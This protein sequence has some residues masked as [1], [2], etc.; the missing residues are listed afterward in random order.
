MIEDVWFWHFIGLNWSMRNC[1]RKLQQTSFLLVECCEL[2]EGFD[3]HVAGGVWCL[4]HSWFTYSYIR[5]HEVMS[6]ALRNCRWSNNKLPSH[7]AWKLHTN[8]HSF[9]SSFFLFVW[10]LN[11]CVAS[12]RLNFWMFAWK[13]FDQSCLEHKFGNEKVAGSTFGCRSLLRSSLHENLHGKCSKKLHFN[14]LSFP[15]SYYDP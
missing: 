10:T 2:F 8:L 7:F 1:S 13:S 14:P 12:L 5:Y 11:L 4:N 9:L 15:L 3:S 6:Q